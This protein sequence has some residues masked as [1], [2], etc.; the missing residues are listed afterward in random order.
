MALVISDTQALR[1]DLP[2]VE[3]FDTGCDCFIIFHPNC[4]AQVA[5]CCIMVSSCAVS[6][7]SPLSQTVCF[8]ST[9]LR[10]WAEYQTTHCHGTKPQYHLPLSPQITLVGSHVMECSAP[11]D[12]HYANGT[13]NCATTVPLESRYQVV[14]MVYSG[15]V[16]MCSVATSICCWLLQGKPPKYLP[17]WAS[18][19]QCCRRSKKICRMWRSSKWAGLL[20]RLKGG[21]EDG[22]A[23]PSSS[24]KLPL[25]SSLVFSYQTCFV[26]PWPL[27]QST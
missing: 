24:Y 16:L 6:V 27:L 19:W 18:P 7:T 26:C 21:Q 12:M 11:S 9:I 8:L 10:M 4:T 20:K 22:R 13:K 1:N 25:F 3:P 23:R 15:G 2:C 17:S 5:P 14:V